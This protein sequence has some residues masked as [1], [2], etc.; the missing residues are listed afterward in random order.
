MLG[1]VAL[2]AAAIVAL[3]IFKL[4]RNNLAHSMG[5]QNSYVQR[6]D[7]EWA[8]GHRAALPIVWT[9]SGLAAILIL[10]GWATAGFTPSSAPWL[11]AALTTTGLSLLL[12]SMRSKLK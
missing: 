4:S 9:G 8:A 6:G 12:G 11:L 1:L 7:D 2:S 5:Y 3:A 10:A